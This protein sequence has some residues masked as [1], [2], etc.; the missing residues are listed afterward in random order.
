MNKMLTAYKKVH[1]SIIS[2]TTL[3]Q[4]ESA[5]RLV[6]NFNRLF[7][8]YK[9]TE[10][11]E[12]LL[13]RKKFLIEME[14]R[15][16][17]YMLIGPPGI[18]KSTYIKETLLPYGEYTGS[19]HGVPKPAATLVLHLLSVKLYTLCSRSVSSEP[20]AADEL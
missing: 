10:I 11:L 20:Q 4:V 5:K 9:L 19:D 15:P 1:Q 14:L 2:C 18:G 8:I 13:N 7:N 12:I 3:E 16:V 6:V 17:V